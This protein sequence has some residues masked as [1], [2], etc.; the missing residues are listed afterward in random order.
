MSDF[1]PDERDAE[2]L[3]LQLR[4]RRRLLLVMALL[5]PPLLVVVYCFPPGETRWYPP[6]LLHAATGLHCIGCGGTRCVYAL[7]HGDLRQALAYHFLAPL[8]LPFFLVWVAQHA[9]A[10]LR[11]R[12]APKAWLGRRALWVLG[13]VVLVFGIVRNIPVEPC[14]ELAPHKLAPPAEEIR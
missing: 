2:R 3:A 7:M 1:R 14:S 12:P 10:T 11:G 5:V 8:V 9:V 13:V 6:C 4:D